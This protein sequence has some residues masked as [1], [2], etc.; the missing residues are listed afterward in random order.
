MRRLGRVFALLLMG[1]GT[2]AL[3]V[4]ANQ[5]FG[6]AGLVIAAAVGLLITAAALRL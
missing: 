5:L 2:V 6:L 3:A 1:I 4:Y